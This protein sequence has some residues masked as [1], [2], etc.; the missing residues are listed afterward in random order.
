MWPETDIADGTRFLKVKFNNVVKSLP[1]STKF[2]TLS[3]TEHFRVIHDR[4]VKVCRLCIQPGHVVRECPSFRCFRCDKQGHYAREC[5]EANCDVCGMRPGLFVCEMLAVMEE[6]NSEEE[7]SDLYKVEDSE[8]EESVNAEGEESQITW[9]KEETATTWEDIGSEKSQGEVGLGQRM[10]ERKKKESTPGKEMDP[11]DL[12]CEDG[13]GKKVKNNEDEGDNAK[14]KEENHCGGRM[15]K[16]EGGGKEKEGLE[17]PVTNAEEDMDMSEGK[18]LNKR[19]KKRGGNTRQKV[20]AQINLNGYK[21]Y[22]KM[23]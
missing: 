15:K 6:A 8:E 19:K 3:G 16:D 12:E 7:T 11:K 17:N 4:Q 21:Y 9:G 13:D 5:K 18:M 20:R 1:Y 14:G 23:C 22:K 2:E 10:K